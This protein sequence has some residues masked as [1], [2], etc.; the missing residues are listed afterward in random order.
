[1]EEA[2]P[3]QGCVDD[4]WQELGLGFAVSE[5]MERGGGDGEDDWIETDT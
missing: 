1:M 2:F 5:L 4:T 3:E